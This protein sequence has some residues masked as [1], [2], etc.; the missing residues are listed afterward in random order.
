MKVSI[1]T[2]SYN[3][4]HTI[5]ET[6]RSVLGQDYPLVEYIVVDGG[7]NDGTLDVIEKYRDRIASVITEPD[8]GLYN[9]MNKGLRYANGDVVAVLNSDDVYAHTSVVRTVVEVLHTEEVDACYGDLLYVSRDHPEKVVRYWKAGLVGEESF[10]RGWMPPHPTFF[11][12][13]AC[14]EAYGYFNETFRFSADYELM[15]RF[16]H[17]YGV[18]ASYIPEVLVHM[19]TGGVSNSSLRNRLAA[20]KEDRKA[21]VVN[22]LTPSLFTVRLKPIRKI[23]Q[24][25]LR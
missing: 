19:K 9:A 13:R 11:A 2:I 4:V 10:R 1:I 23:G 24:Y 22:G 17:R 16:L 8:T 20:N 5:E 14:Y 21:W 15:L 7:S 6:I 25:F 18:K 12:K 3:A